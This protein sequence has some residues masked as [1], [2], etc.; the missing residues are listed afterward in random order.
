[1]S[2]RAAARYLKK[3][4]QTL[5]NWPLAITSYNYGLAGMIRAVVSRGG[6]R[7][8][9]T[10]Y[11]TGHFKFASKNFYSEFLA[12]L[13]VARK[14]EK[15]DLVKRSRHPG[16][17]YVKLGG[18]IHIVRIR[19]HFNLSHATIKNLN[20]ALLAPV[21]TGEKLIPKDYPLRLP[22]TG[23]IRKSI[24]SLPSSFFRKK[25]LRNFYHIVRRGD[26][27][28]SIA[29]RHGV[30]L[31]KLIKA[32]NLDRYARIYINQKLRIPQIGPPPYTRIKGEKK[33]KRRQSLSLDKA[34][35]VP[36]LTA[37]KKNRPAARQRFTL[38]TNNS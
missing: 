17:C 22:D 8:I 6:Y 23:N 16:T 14:L 32:N 37:G 25:Q 7:Q 30:S 12:A 34:K 10:G 1:L 33:K 38:P 24:S 19:D 3:S 31:K 26:T 36:L 18:F 21:F 13:E 15:T 4:Y 5:D 20:P 9:F 28:G 29:K 2:T 11:D 27:A 35:T